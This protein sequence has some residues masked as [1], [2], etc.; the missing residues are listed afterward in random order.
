MGLFSRKDE[1]PQDITLLSDEDFMEAWTAEAQ[2]LDD[3]RAKVREFAKEHARRTSVAKALEV[4][5][6][7][8]PGDRQALSQVMQAY[9]IPSQEN[10]NG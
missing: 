3:S 4:L 2:R 9:G 5:A 10:V 6:P 1:V 7:L 8:A